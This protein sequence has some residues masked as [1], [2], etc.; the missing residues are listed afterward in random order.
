MEVK[1]QSVRMK[2]K[3]RDKSADAA[4]K[5][6]WNVT[7][8]VYSSIVLKYRSEVLYLSLFFS[9]NF[10]LRLHYQQCKEVKMGPSAP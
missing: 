9:C 8:S 10:I 5:Q 1:K 3:I 7:K 2:Q 4:D 6:W